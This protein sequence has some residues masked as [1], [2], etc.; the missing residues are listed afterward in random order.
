LRQET[1]ISCGMMTVLA[2]NTL[3]AKSGN[4]MRI[5]NRIAKF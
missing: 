5:R 2:D 3:A 1:P 4:I